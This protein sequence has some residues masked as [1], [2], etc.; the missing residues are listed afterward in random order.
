[1]PFFFFFPAVRYSAVW[2]CRHFFVLPLV[3]GHVGYFQVFATLD[4]IAVN[5]PHVCHFLRCKDIEVM[6]FPRDTETGLWVNY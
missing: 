3:D 1:M 2:L 4:S 5:D 6:L